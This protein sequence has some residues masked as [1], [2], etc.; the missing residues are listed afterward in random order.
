[1]H[2]AFYFLLVAILIV[3]QPLNG[4]AKDSVNT[5]AIS[6]QGFDNVSKIIEQMSPKQ[7]EDIRKQAESMMPE[8]EK[9]TPKEIEEYNKQLL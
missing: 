1:M 3:I 4:L 7:L 9:M 8:L 2:K 5:K 6:N